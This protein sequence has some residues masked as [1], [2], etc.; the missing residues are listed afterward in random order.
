MLDSF[1][2]GEIAG[3]Y[4]RAAAPAGTLRTPG[5]T[6]APVTTAITI[7]LTA[8]VSGPVLATT[9]GPVFNTGPRVC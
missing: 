5:G 6:T 4:L 1:I 7:L 9:N 3:R 8:T 2:T